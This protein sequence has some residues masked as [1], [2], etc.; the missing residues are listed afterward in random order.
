[1]NKLTDTQRRML[2]ILTG[3]RW[4]EVVPCSSM[5]TPD[6]YEYCSCGTFRLKITRPHDNCTFLSPDD[7]F[8]VLKALDYR[9]V[10][11]YTIRDLRDEGFIEKFM[12][13]VAGYLQ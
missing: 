10:P 6:G 12:I 3:K 2:A 4:H 9:K 11:D 7:F 1:M 13:E 5:E 8:E